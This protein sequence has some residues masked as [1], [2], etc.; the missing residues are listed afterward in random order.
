ALTASA[1]VEAFAIAM[2]AAR[3]ADHLA[4][5]LMISIPL[6]I[7]GMAPSGGLSGVMSPTVIGIESLEFGSWMTTIGSTLRSLW[8]VNCS[9][10]TFEYASA[11]TARVGCTGPTLICGPQYATLMP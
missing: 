11:S 4:A 1:F 7:G 10:S 5:P 8:K 9:C 3:I 2:R 6:G